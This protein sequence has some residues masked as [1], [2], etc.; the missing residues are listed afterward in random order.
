MNEN[1]QIVMYRVP[2]FILERTR[3]ISVDQNNNKNKHLFKLV[4]YRCHNSKSKVIHRT[5]LLQLQILSES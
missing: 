3:L 5:Q 1:K 2:K 4:L